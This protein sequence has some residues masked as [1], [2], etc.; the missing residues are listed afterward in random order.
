MILQ[1]SSAKI[2]KK[3]K[4]KAIVTHLFRII[5]KK[6]VTLQSQFYK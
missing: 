5:K 3:F 2:R 6:Y 1:N 4:K